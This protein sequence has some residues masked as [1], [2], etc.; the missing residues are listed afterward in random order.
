MGQGTGQ[1][2]MGQAPRWRLPVSMEKQ[3]MRQ[4]GNSSNFM[5]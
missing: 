2:R 1:G 4:S 5:S 3:V